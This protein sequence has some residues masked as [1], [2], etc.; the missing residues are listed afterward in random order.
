MRLLAYASICGYGLASFSDMERQFAE[1]TIHSQNSTRGFSSAFLK[2]VEDYG[3]WC[4]FN[5]NYGGKG[6]PV[7][8]IDTV[9]KTLAQAY[10]CAIMDGEDE[11]ELCV[12]YE[13]FYVAPSIF[14]IGD[15]D[16]LVLQ[17]EGLNAGKTKC[18]IRSCIIENQFVLD[19]FQALQGTGVNPA[20]SRSAGFDTKAGCPVKAGDGDVDRSCCGYYPFRRPFKS[21][22]GDR[23]CCGRRTYNP[24]V[25]TCCSDLV[26]R[27]SC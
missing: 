16:A 8:G 26:P 9:C 24:N 11:G 12:P 19:S 14:S 4:S 27:I 23:S 17:C 10:D 6:L 25:L 2:D 5:D 13:A 7:D 18:E 22:T 20:F 21:G 3:C 1:L 15:T